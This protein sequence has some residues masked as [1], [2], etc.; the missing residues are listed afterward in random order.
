MSLRL[1]INAVGLVSGGGLNHLTSLLPALA[2]ARPSWQLTVYL[3]AG[4]PDLAQPG[5]RFVRVNRKSWKRVGWDTVTVARRAV[6]EG[7]DVLLNLANYG[8]VYARVPSL[9]YQANP[10]YFDR[11]WVKRRSARW[12]AE[13][14]VRRL[15]AFAAMRRS[16]AVLV[17]SAGMAGYLRS[18]RTCPCE[19]PIEVV[20][21][22]VDTSR[23][24]FDPASPGERVRVVSLS[25]AYP[26]K[27]QG[28]LVDLVVE[29]GNRGLEVELEATIDDADDPDYVA[30]LRAKIRDGGLEDRVRFVG[31]V[32]AGTFMRSADVSVLPSIT[33][34]FGFAVVEA[35]ASGVPVVASR[36]PSSVEVL[37]D[38]GWYFDPGDASGAAD[39]VMRLLGTER[40]ALEQKLRAARRVAEGYTWERNA[41]RVAEIVER[42]AVVDPDG[43]GR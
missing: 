23:F 13:A 25:L 34:S 33:E 3:S 7:A 30:L 14:V 28:L 19:V 39:Q 43:D 36:I 4:G 31:R 9:L 18:W 5:V 37:G 42:A 41:A 16:A 1:H 20:P 11:A 27:D 32:D 2:A 21:H 17:P 29:L 26:H 38:L 8:P 40:G 10:V 35:M 24:G 12:Q 6:A 22:G 15:L